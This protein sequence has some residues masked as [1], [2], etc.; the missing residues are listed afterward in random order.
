MKNKKLKAILSITGYFLLTLALCFSGALVFHS[1]YYELI[2]VSG[3][4]MS[5]TLN[6]SDI[7]KDGTIV[8]F[9]IVDSHKSAI[10]HIKRFSIV[11]TYYST[12][13]YLN[14]NL[15]PNPKQKIKRVIALPGETF[16]IEGSKLYVLNEGTNDFDYIPYTFN[17]NPDVES[18]NSSKDIDETT[19]GEDE[20]WVLGDNRANSNDSASINEPVKKEYLIGV[21]VA[22]EGKAELKVKKL[23]CQNCGKSYK[24][25][26]ERCTDETCRGDLTPEYELTHKRYHWPKYY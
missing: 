12:D 16:K 11:S 9:G 26:T 13:Y 24:N 7:E 8:D 15:K 19:L 21:L 22:I 1:V 3:I 20:Y 18:G 2:Y 23:I 4:S 17:I 14:G 6:G 10:N 25:G 5:P